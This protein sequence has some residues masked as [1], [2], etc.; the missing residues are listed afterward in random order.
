MR[1]KS[2][3]NDDVIALECVEQLRKRGLMI[4]KVQEGLY[5]DVAIVHIKPVAKPKPRC[6]LFTEHPGGF[7]TMRSQDGTE[8]FGYT[9][10]VKPISR[11]D[12]NRLYRSP[13][14]EFIERL[15]ALGVEVSDA[16]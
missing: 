5:G 9:E 15:R 11:E 16:D 8:R 4:T 3:N 2:M 13:Y 6:W 10:E 14:G 7:V 1:P 12:V